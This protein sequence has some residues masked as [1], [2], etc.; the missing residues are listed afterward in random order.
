MEVRPA[1]RAL[2]PSFRAG[3]GG[4]FHEFGLGLHVLVL[5][6]QSEA[7]LSSV[8]LS[9]LS[10]VSQSLAPILPSLWHGCPLAGICLLTGGIRD[11]NDI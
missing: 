10:R 4:S 11:H 3:S 7:S 2:H 1:R 9:T 8:V 5:I 6:P